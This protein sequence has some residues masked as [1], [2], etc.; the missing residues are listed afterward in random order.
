[1][2]TYQ[3]TAPLSG[4]ST[5]LI[6]AGQWPVSYGEDC[7]ILLKVWQISLLCRP[8]HLPDI[9]PIKHIWC[10]VGQQLDFHGLLANIPDSF[11]ICLQIVWKEVSLEHFH[12][13]CDSILQ[14]LEALIAVHGGFTPHWNLVVRN[15]VE[16]CNSNHL[17]IVMY[18]I[19]HMS[20]Q[21]DVSFLVLHFKK[22]M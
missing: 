6:S 20:F 1:M 21:S 9:S 12:F 5:F 19:C 3:N 15:H 10:M 8:A 13:I 4:N 2:I 11:W 17:C 7:A 18:V 14:I 16:L 22:V